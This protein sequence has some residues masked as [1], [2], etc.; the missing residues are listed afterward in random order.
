MKKL[1]LLAAL[2]LL[3][4]A[5]SGV[6]AGWVLLAP[7]PLGT[8]GSASACVMEATAWQ[9]RAREGEHWVAEQA[10]LAPTAF[11]LEAAHHAAD[12]VERARG[13]RCVERS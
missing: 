3:V 7:Y 9:A 12:Q 1:I 10:R 5:P 2:G 4:A 13:A 8:F 6:D 11:W